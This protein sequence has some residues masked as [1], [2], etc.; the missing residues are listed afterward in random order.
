MANWDEYYN[1]ATNDMIENH[2][3]ENTSETSDHVIELSDEQLAD[4]IRRLSGIDQTTGF[5]K[6]EISYQAYNLS[7]ENDINQERVYSVANAAVQISRNSRYADLFVVDIIFKSADDTELKLFW[8]RLQ[9]HL[10]NQSQ[11]A[12]QDWIFYI[13]LLERASVTQQTH[14]QDTLLTANI[15]NPLLCYLTREVPNQAIH[16]TEIDHEMLGGNIIRM[17]VPTTLLTYAINDAIDT[18]ELKGE[19]QREFEDARYLDMQEQ[20]GEQS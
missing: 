12:N 10:Q 19:V 4:Y 3:I 5:A 2:T 8:G 20:K 7:D 16:D 18:N 9:K 14:K 15:I 17:L 1:E 13:N 6:S 11:Y